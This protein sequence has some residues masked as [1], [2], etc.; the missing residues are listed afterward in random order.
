MRDTP[1][2]IIFESPQ[3]ISL[4]TQFGLLYTEALQ[5]RSQVEEARST[6]QNN[7]HNHVKQIEEMEV[8]IVLN[9][10]FLFLDVLIKLKIIICYF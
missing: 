3:Y 1:E 4:K 10:I 6:I 9:L 8:S 2:S 5:L 7:R